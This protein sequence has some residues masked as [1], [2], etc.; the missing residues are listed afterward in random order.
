M[1]KDQ[2]TQKVPTTAKKE[3][4]QKLQTQL[5]E[6]KQEL[7]KFEEKTNQ[8][9]QNVKNEYEERVADIREKITLVEHKLQKI[10]NSAEGAW[11]DLKKGTED[12]LHAVENA[13]KKAFERF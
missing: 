13:V 5:D 2:N 6:W 10:G 3:L 9:E 1:D 7:Q 4:I 8:I 12:A 11:D